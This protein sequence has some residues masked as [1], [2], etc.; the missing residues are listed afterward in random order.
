MRML[1]VLVGVSCC[2]AQQNYSGWETFGG[3]PENLHYSSL[4]QINTKNVKRLQVAWTFES[5]D[6]FPGSEIQCNPIVVNGVLYATTPKL[7]VVAL[8]AATGKL[9]WSFDGLD[10][11]RPNHPSRG[12]MH[13][14]DGKQSR[15]LFPLGHDLLSIDAETGKLDAAFGH[16]GKVD[17]RAAFDRPPELINVSVTS[18]GAIYRDLVILGSSL[19]EVAPIDAGRHSSLRRAN[20]RAALDVSHHSAP[21]RVRL[22]HVAAGGLEVHRRRQQLVGPS[23]GSEARAGVRAHRLGVVRFLWS[24][25]AGR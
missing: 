11:K 14:S 15:I 21:G 12:L 9:I 25:P 3:G 19:P 20:G 17:M 16:E 10:G 24:R 23:G 4:K 1:L 7:R 22:R 6:A 18:P 13:W 2:L 5:G 8:D